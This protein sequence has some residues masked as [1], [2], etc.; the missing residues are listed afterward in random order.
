[1]KICGHDYKIKFVPHFKGKDGKEYC[2]EIDYSNRFIGIDSSM[3]KG[4]I[5]ETLLHE[6]I[7]G[8][9]WHTNK[10]TDHNEQAVQAISNGLYQLGVGK[11]LMEKA[12]PKEITNG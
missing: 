12:K 8:I 3:R 1:M 4:V 9:M 10:K 11:F 5:E 6:V 2:G 7:H